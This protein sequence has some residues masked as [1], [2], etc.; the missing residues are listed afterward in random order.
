MVFPS[1]LWCCSL[2]VMEEG[3]AFIFYPSVWDSIFVLIFP[4]ATF[5]A[6]VGGCT[7]LWNI[8]TNIPDYII[9]HPENLSK[10]FIH[11]RMHKWLS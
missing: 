11:Q 4:Y 10:S 8:G 9:S 7:F 2:V 3:A 5:R 6:E 1:G